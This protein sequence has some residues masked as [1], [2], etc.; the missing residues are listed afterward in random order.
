MVMTTPQTKSM[1]GRVRKNKGVAGVVHSLEQVCAARCKTTTRNYHIDRF[2]GN[3]SIWPQI[4]N[5]QHLTQGV[6]LPV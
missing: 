6:C 5:S 2:D 4:F 3:L 1:I